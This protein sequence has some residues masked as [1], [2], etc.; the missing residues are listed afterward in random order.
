[1]SVQP[2][3][4]PSFLEEFRLL[5]LESMMRDLQK[6]SS[7]ELKRIHEEIERILSSREE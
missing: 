3:Y 6:L 7:D 2:Q 1:M 5:K 4:I